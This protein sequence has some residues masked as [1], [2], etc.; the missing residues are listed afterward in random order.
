MYS[1]HAH[2]RDCIRPDGRSQILASGRYM[3][4]VGF[5]SIALPPALLAMDNTEPLN[6]TRRYL[7]ANL[8]TYRYHSNT[9]QKVF[10]LPLGNEM[11]EVMRNYSSSFNLS[12]TYGTAPQS[13]YL[14]R[15]PTNHHSS[16][17]NLY[18]TK[19]FSTVLSKPPKGRKGIPPVFLFNT[20]A[21]RFDVF[22][23][24]FTRDDQLTVIPFENGMWYVED[25]S[26]KLVRKVLERLNN[27][28]GEPE[29]AMMISKMKTENVQILQDSLAI[30]AYRRKQSEL[31]EASRIGKTSIR[32]K[33]NKGE[34]EADLQRLTYGYVTQDLCGT[35]SGDDT[36]HQALPAFPIPEFVLSSQPEGSMS[37]VQETEKMDLVFYVGWSLVG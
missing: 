4:T 21:A 32:Y 1:G 25:L 11:K 2:Q 5:S 33:N 23:G 28:P 7:D 36:P 17:I 6:M 22:K 27:L 13:Y 10:D 8:A 30:S 37:Q 19:V 34:D 31:F 9:S 16:L 18:A 12:Y 29:L 3:E 20:G 35:L 24:A 15:Y 26:M 14:D